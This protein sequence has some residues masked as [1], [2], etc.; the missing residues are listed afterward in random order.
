[1]GEAWR[2]KG[3]FS[4]DKCS[5]HL[6]IFHDTCN[7]YILK[8]DKEA[9]LIDFGSGVV[10]DR[11][12]EIGVERIDAILHT[13]HHRDQC[14]GDQKAVD[15]GI[16]IH[17]PEHERRLFDRAELFW[18][19]KQLWDMY[20]VRSTLFSLT[21]NVRVSDVLKDF[22]SFQWKGYEFTIIPTPG[23]TLGS[24]SIVGT[25][26]D[27]RVAFTGD[28]IYSPGKVQTLFDMQYNYSE[29][30]GLEAA[31]LSLENLE[32]RAPQVIYPSHGE[33]MTQGVSALRETRQNLTSYFMLR[34]N[35]IQPV[36]EQR[37]TRITAHLLAAEYACS[38]FYAVLSDDGHALLVDYGSPSMELF[39]PIQPHFEEGETVRFM[40]HSIHR[41]MNE[42]GVKKIDAVIP[43]HY[44]DD[45]VNGIPYLQSQLGVECWAY[46]GIQSMLENPGNE[47]IGCVMPYPIRIDRTFKD[48]DTLHWKGYDLIA[49]HTPGHT[50]Y[51]VSLFT[52]IDERSVGFTGDNIFIKQYRAPSVVYRN[53]FQK[54]SHERAFRIY[55]EYHPEIICGGHE[56]QY[57]VPPE[58]Y[59]TLLKKARA[60]TQHFELLL[61]ND[62][63]SG[64]DPFWVQIYP[65]RSVAGPGDTIE[66]SI[67]VSN[68][69]GRAAQA[70]ASMVLPPSWK[71]EPEPIALKLDPDT[72][73]E[74]GVKIFV[75]ESY[76]FE[77]PR[78]AVAVDVELEGRYL[79]QI[80]EAVVTGREYR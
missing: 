30:D 13:H 80:A 68:C 74:C 38:Y 45:H 4:L 73:S 23:H 69:S 28:L 34:N 35:G 6:F 10:L 21:R 78:I 48:G 15:L 40:E 18:A 53:R 66:L 27:T 60:L 31:I 1:M 25:I 49:R 36:S 56:V 58:V 72:G 20:N 12:S 11:L 41:L 43:T 52:N 54:D 14:Q 39:S 37:F 29:T 7:V 26:D 70:S 61:P 64:L 65:Y 51:A 62:G 2:A 59:Q 8:K 22:G 77:L 47:Q 16:P 42:Y 75:P 71:Y 9:V 33:P 24:I 67:R 63:C 44:H 79:G 76:R 32:Y 57:N 17:V 50:E 19:T 5:P 46:E 55:A 3:D